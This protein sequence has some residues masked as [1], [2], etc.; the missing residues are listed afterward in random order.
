MITITT[1]I[2]IV[3]PPNPS[4][5]AQE[6]FSGEVSLAASAAL[7]A[8][9]AGT[10]GTRSSDTAG[11]LTMGAGHGIVTGDVIDVSWAGGEQLG[12]AAT[13]DGNAVTIASG[14]GDALPV[15]TTAIVAS[16][17][18]SLDQQFDGDDVVLWFINGTGKMTVRYLDAA[19]AEIHSVT[20]DSSASVSIWSAGRG[21]NPFAGESIARVTLSNHAAA[22]ATFYQNGVLS[23]TYTT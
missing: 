3:A 5:S 8:G 18:R 14:T 4:V 15:A 12:C 1:N 7:A 9:L 16:V 20:L 6:S 11:I 19:D 23:G 21:T 22:A 13:V 2:N 10:L 17:P